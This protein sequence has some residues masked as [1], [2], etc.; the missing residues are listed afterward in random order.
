MA[1]LNNRALL[2]LLVDSI[3]DAG[4]NCLIVSPNKPFRLRIY[5]EDIKATEVEIYIWNCTHGGGQKRKDYEYRIQLTTEIPRHS[6][7][8]TTVLLGWHAGY[9]VFAGFDMNWHANQ[10]SKSPSIQIHEDT[11]KGAHQKA[12]S[13]AQ[14]Q[15]GEL[16]VAFRPALLV[17]YIFNC[18]ALHEQ[19]IAPRDLSL[20][21]NLDEADPKVLPENSSNT[22]DATIAAFARKYRA[23][24]FRG[25]ILSAYRHQ[26][27]A[28]G[29]QLKL[30][31]AAH[32]IPVASDASTDETTNGIALCKSHH[33][34]YDRNLISFDTDYTIEVSSTEQSRL[35]AENFAGGLSYFKK[36]LRAAIILPADKRDHPSA[37]YIAHS[38][39]I[40]R[41]IS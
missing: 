4:W 35:T 19:N 38:R 20:L 16:A 21:N 11:L 36:G 6:P 14:R 5:T 1:T 2:S 40:R 29:V 32:I 10:D 25:R 41:W 17:D 22:R 13:V 23:A 33:W 31:D 26:C 12:F 37:E 28:C 27:A 24:D 15:N 3:V 9:Q 8:A 39:K 7:A 18:R 30:I 34:A